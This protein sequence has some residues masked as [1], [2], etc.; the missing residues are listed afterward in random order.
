MSFLHRCPLARKSAT[1]C[2]WR[3]TS[4]WSSPEAPRTSSAASSKRVNTSPYWDTLRV[5]AMCMW[6]RTPTCRRPWRLVSSKLFSRL[7]EILEWSIYFLK[8]N[9]LYKCRPC[10]GYGTVKVKPISIVKCVCS[11]YLDL[12]GKCGHSINSLAT[13]F[14]LDLDRH[15]R[16]DQASLIHN[17]VSIDSSAATAHFQISIPPVSFH[18]NMVIPTDVEGLS[19]SNIKIK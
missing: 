17:Q 16:M 14:W 5:S 8:V 7:L 15:Y 11:L 9:P 6:I 3:S 10:S 12:T 19:V 4:T 18:P 2:P 13:I 1:S